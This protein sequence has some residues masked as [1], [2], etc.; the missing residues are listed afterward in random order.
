M[1]REFSCA[2]IFQILDLMPI[3]ICYGGFVIPPECGDF[4]GLTVDE[5]LAVADSVLAGYAIVGDYGSTYSGV[6]FTA[7]C[8]NELYDNCDLVFEL[9]PIPIPHVEDPDAESRMDELMP[10]EQI[11][12]TEFEVTGIVPN[13]LL[14]STTISFALPTSG[15][16]TV[17]IYDIQG[18]SVNALLGHQLPAGYH[19]VVWNGKDVH[20]SKVA[21]G[22]YFCRVRFADEPEIM[23]KL[24]KLQ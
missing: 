3:V 15:K 10:T 5:F 18:R 4:A 1:N 21:S 16:V 12:P 2:G 14:G 20:G 17:E 7:T 8:L 13:P 24:I 23:K 11:L 9:S 19:G 6:N 22:V